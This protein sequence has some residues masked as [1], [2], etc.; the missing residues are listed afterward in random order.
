MGNS[1]ISE[2][3]D[4]VYDEV[5]VLPDDI[6]EELGVAEHRGF[7]SKLSVTDLEQ[8]LFFDFDDTLVS[9]HNL[10]WRVLFQ[11]AV[12]LVEGVT[13]K[14]AEGI[15]K[16]MRGG[17]S[18]DKWELAVRAY[19]A[20]N[21]LAIKE[22]ELSSKDYVERGFLDP[23][24]EIVPKDT[25]RLAQLLNRLG[26]PLNIVTKGDPQF[27]ADKLSLF[28]EVLSNSVVGVRP[29]LINVAIVP[30]IGEKEVSE[31]QA[32]K[33]QFSNVNIDYLK[34]P[35]RNN[36]NQNKGQVLADIAEKNGVV[37]MFYINDKEKENRDIREVSRE[38]ERCDLTPYRIDRRHNGES[39][40]VDIYKTLERIDQS[41]NRYEEEEF[42]GMLSE[43]IVNSTKRGPEQL[44]EQSDF[45]SI[46]SLE[47]VSKIV[48]E[49][50][51]IAMGVGTN[52]LIESDDVPR[53]L[54]E[55]EISG[56][57]DVLLVLG[58]PELNEISDKAAEL[59]RKTKNRDVQV[60]FS[61]ADTIW[62]KYMPLSEAGT[63]KNLCYLKVLR[64]EL[65]LSDEDSDWLDQ[66]LV[67][68]ESRVRENAP[69]VDRI[70]AQKRA[71]FRLKLLAKIKLSEKDV[72]QID[73]EKET[74]NHIRNEVRG[75]LSS[76]LGKEGLQNA[77]LELLPTF[78]ELQELMLKRFG[79]ERVD[80]I[81][82]LFV[83]D[84]VVL[85]E[86]A[87]N[88]PGNFFRTIE[89]LEAD[90]QGKVG[91]M[92]V[93][94]RDFHAVRGYGTY[95]YAALMK[96]VEGTW[97]FKLGANILDKEIVST[98][99]SLEEEFWNSERSE[100]NYADYIA[101]IIVDRVREIG[102]KDLTRLEKAS[103]YFKLSMAIDRAIMSLK[104]KYS[105]QNDKQEKF[106]Q[107]NF[108]YRLESLKFQKH[109][110]IENTRLIVNPQTD[111]KC[112]PAETERY[113][114]EYLDEIQVVLKKDPSTISLAEWQKAHALIG[115]LF[116]GVFTNAQ[117]MYEYHASG[118]INPERVPDFQKMNKALQ[119]MVNVW[120][121][122]LE[123]SIQNSSRE[124]KQ[125]NL[126]KFKLDPEKFVIPAPEGQISVAMPKRPSKD[127]I[128]AA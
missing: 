123:V 73:I 114:Q 60:V 102:E 111:V 74:N 49:L 37:Q 10:K 81:N 4:A 70:I 104:L 122:A 108:Y 7:D 113:T 77:G 31:P 96:Q 76:V 115:D 79:R 9:S 46:A 12:D 65:D 2:I 118:I 15:Y 121:D 21:E 59:I 42:L 5:V 98:A 16:A 124:L 120:N 119:E 91:K 39:G 24:N 84:R 26:V 83:E 92:V 105:S 86:K 35:V 97:S 95:L 103:E 53:F 36:V 1:N 107:G 82:Q 125:K 62:D 52:V 75:K 48:R 23:K 63:L 90:L 94:S 99:V 40:T 19:A 68:I 3:E 116:D 89:L 54:E 51:G 11:Y 117:K 30:P 109:L 8:R 67:N 80:S 66:Q 78:L 43:R 57:K 85:E 50:Y 13:L 32:K 126:A 18:M 27:Q 72:P 61:G 127:K 87:E 100:Q 69:V 38:T 29:M 14:Q 22:L 128:D 33:L 44:L 106:D 56:R 34:Y 93:V 20:K 64:D 45:P 6:A 88:T 101:E 71:D 17:F 58:G 28:A 55:M 110:M 47:D 112:C 41:V 25:I